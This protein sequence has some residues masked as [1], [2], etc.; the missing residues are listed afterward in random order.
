MILIDETK[1]DK[2]TL[3]ELLVAMGNNILERGYTDKE[4]ELLI[5][6]ISETPAA[7]EREEKFIK[8]AIAQV[9][10]ATF[11]DYD[12]MIEKYLPLYRYMRE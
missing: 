7:D 4:K 10:A 2:R 1:L 8:Y 6:E 3:C 5:A 11:L 12:R 9:E